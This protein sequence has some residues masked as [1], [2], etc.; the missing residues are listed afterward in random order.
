[1]FGWRCVALV[2]FCSDGFGLI[3]ASCA[4]VDCLV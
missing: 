3:V 2:V 4:V 1:M